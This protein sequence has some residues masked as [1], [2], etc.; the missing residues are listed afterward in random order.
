[1]KSGKE[2]EAVYFASESGLTERFSPVSLL[3]SYLHNSRKNATTILKNGNYSTAAT[4]CFES[5]YLSQFPIVSSILIYHLQILLIWLMFQEE[6]GNVE[7]NSI[8]TIIKCVEDHKLES[9]FS[10]DSLRKRATQLEKAKV[11][12][13]KSS[14]GASKPPNK[15]AHGGGS[16][17][18]SGRG[19]GPSAFRPA[20]APKFS[21]STY[22]SFGRRNPAPPPQHSPAGRYSGPFSYPAQ[23]VYD[24]PTPPPYASTYGGPHPQTPTIPQQHYSLSVD[25]MGAGGMRASGSYGGQTSYNAYDYAAAAPPTYHTQ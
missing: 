14:A 10:I 15:R 16:G 25:D 13:K 7:L 2:I 6:S 23:G 21:N 19:S 8:K 12:R 9:E 11:E 24:G 5:S 18:G 3:K 20:K 4:V 17:S 22:P 1:M